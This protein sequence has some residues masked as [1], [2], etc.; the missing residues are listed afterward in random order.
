MKERVGVNKKGINTNKGRNK[1]REEKVK[2]EKRMEINDLNQ[3][4][5]LS[6]GE[7]SCKKQKEGKERM[8]EGKQ[9]VIKIRKRKKYKKIWK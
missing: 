6:K 1:G 7:K 4:K 9:N 8:K 2:K 5:R 3:E